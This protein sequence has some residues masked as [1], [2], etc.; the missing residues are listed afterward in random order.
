MNFKDRIV[1]KAMV[2]LSEK[3]VDWDKMFAEWKSLRDDLTKR[4]NLIEKDLNDE[5]WDNEGYTSPH[6]LKELE[7]VNNQMK[8]LEEEAE[9]F[10]MR[11]K[12]N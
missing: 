7:E 3:K 5:F 1:K 6:L 12:D 4:F 11:N 2:K 8:V 10:T 9:Q